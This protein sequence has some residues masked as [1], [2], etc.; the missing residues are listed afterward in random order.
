MKLVIWGVTQVLVT[1]RS[2]LKREYT[3]SKIRLNT[4]FDGINR[5][6]PK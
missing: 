1:L 2:L 6:F 4:I 5:N 3:R